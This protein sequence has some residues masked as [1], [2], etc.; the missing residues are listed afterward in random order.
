MTERFAKRFGKQETPTKSTR[1]ADRNTRV[2]EENVTAVD[3]LMKSLS[4]ESQKQTRR[5]MR[6]ISK[7]MVL[8]QRSILHI[9][10]RDLR[11]KCL[12]RLPARLFFYYC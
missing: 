9:I 11:S 8:T 10:H 6:Q 2:T 5:S 7:K 3:K 12:V 4:Q 1:V